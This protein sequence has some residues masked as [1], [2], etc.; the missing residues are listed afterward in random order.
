MDALRRAMM[1]LLVISLPCCSSAQN[2]ALRGF[3]DIHNH[4]FANMAFGGF[5]VAGVPFGPL[6]DSLSEARCRAGHSNLHAM[7]ILG[8][9]LAG[10]DGPIVYGNDGYPNFNG[11]PAFFEVSHQKV[12]EVFLKRAVDGGLR[13]M[14]M[15]AV[16]SPLLCDA[17]KNGAGRTDGRDCNDEMTSIKNQIAAAYGMQ[18]YIDSEA[19]GRGLGW[20]RI[21]TTPGQAR[22]VIR[23]GKLAVVLGVETS[24]LFNCH[25]EPCNWNGPLDELWKLGVRHFFPIHQDKNAFGG[26]SYFQASIQNGTKLL[27]VNPYTFP[28]ISCAYTFP[29]GTLARGGGQCDALGLTATGKEFVT[30]L[31]N[32]G[33]IIDVDH[34]SDRSFAD[35][36]TLAEKLDYPVVASHAGFNAVQQ[37]N[38]DP[39]GSAYRC[40]TRPGPERRRNGGPDLKPGRSLHRRHLSWNGSTRA[41]QVWQEFRNLCA[42]VPVC[43]PARTRHG[44]RY[45]HGLQRA[46]AA[47]RPPIRGESLQRRTS[48]RSG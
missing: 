41:A 28:R 15:M 13:L 16:E 14:V 22:D 44:Y 34:M 23:S 40:G 38:G 3:A 7:D 8:G 47:A 26:P 30:G 24:H 21:V 32:L 39:R 17:V 33:A 25:H 11:W 48:C 12:H 31:M 35:T 43:P 1:L 18:N 10:Y 9:F 42:T 4:E 45:W 20:Y 5:V 46:A 37:R 36:L 29:K 2:E 27:N 6:P 19:G